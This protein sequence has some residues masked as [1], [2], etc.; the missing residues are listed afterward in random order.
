MLAKCISRLDKGRGSYGDVAHA[1]FP[2]LRSL[3]TVLFSMELLGACV[4]LFV[5]FAD[6]L[7]DLIP[8]TNKVYLKIFAG[9]LLTPLSFLPLKVLSFNSVLGIVSCFSSKFDEK[10]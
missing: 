4:A 2:R 10:T 5:L 6:T 3:I 1:A 7:H 8:G 9:F